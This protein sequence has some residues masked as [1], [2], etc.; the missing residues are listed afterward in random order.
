MSDAPAEDVTPPAEDVKVAASI[1]GKK[2]RSVNSELQKEA[3]RANGSLGGR[4]PKNK[5]EK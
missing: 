5:K 2:G 4:P 1:L 3:S